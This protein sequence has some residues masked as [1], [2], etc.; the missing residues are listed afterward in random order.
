MISAQ[1][2]SQVAPQKYFI[3]FMDR[4]NSPYSVNTPQQYLSNRAIERRQR[5]GIPIVENDLPVNPNYI[6]IIRSYPVTILNRSKWLNGITVYSLNPSLIDSIC[7]LPFVKRVIKNVNFDSVIIYNPVDKYTLY[8]YSLDNNLPI[9]EIPWSFIRANT[10]SW[11]GA[12]Y[13][14]V[15]MVGADS[16]HAMGYR[17]EGIVIAVL[18]AGFMNSD[19]VKAFDSLRFNNQILGTRDFVKPGNNVFQEDD[20]GTAVLSVMGANIPGQLVGTAPRAAYWLLRT[21]DVSSEYLIEEYNWISAAEF[22]DSAGADIINS[23]LGYTR[24]NDPAQDHTCEDMNGNTTPVTIG[25]NIAAGKGMVVVNSAGNNGSNSWQCMSA[26]A[27]GFGVLAVAAVDSN[28]NYASFSSLG[29]VGNRV[30]PN[31]A[32]MGSLTAVSSS[33]GPVIRSSGTSFSAPVISGATACLLQAAKNWSSGLI[34]RSI[35][36]SSNKINSPDKYLGY[37]VPDFISALQHMS[38]QTQEP[39]KKS[40]VISPNPTAGRTVISVAGPL[41]GSAEIR[42]FNL[43]GNAV[44][45]ILLP[46][47]AGELLIRAGF[48]ISDL[49]DGVYM[50]CLQDTDGV[51]CELMLKIAL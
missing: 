9:P 38:V 40:L 33:T 30:K 43:T 7:E 47:G 14:Q 49:P 8:K 19:L 17:G 41:E 2:F 36:L 27:D 4:H 26:P 25:A 39:Q 22:A 42:I 11:Y 44:K 23:S 34:I 5:Q 21:E 6:N 29:E 10:E 31:V 46:T 24:F 18:D 3:E 12:S 35:E 13:A 16:M 50:V 51:N 45:T 37:G 15:H 28:G 1:S 32:A 48:D 20:H